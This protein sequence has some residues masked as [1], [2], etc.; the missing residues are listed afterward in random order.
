MKNLAKQ[1]A[2]ATEDIKA[3]VQNIQTISVSTVEAIS[4]I[5]HSISA[6]N[7]SSIQ[8]SQAVNMQGG[9]TE[10]IAGSVGLMAHGMDDISNRISGMTDAAG[11]VSLASAEIMDVASA[12]AENA[13]NL[14]QIIRQ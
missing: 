12:L 11:K 6:I 1:T 7:G 9:D 14:Q 3:Q 5:N 8:I 10:E 2:Q 13:S 4:G